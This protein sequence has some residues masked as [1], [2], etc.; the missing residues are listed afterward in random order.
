M[1]ESLFLGKSWRLKVSHE[2]F[3]FLFKLKKTNKMESFVEFKCF[4]VPK[5]IRVD[6]LKDRITRIVS[7][8]SNQW[9]NRTW[10][11]RAS[12]LWKVKE[13]TRGRLIVYG[14]GITYNDWLLDTINH[15]AINKKS[16]RAYE[17][18]RIVVG[19]PI[20]WHCIIFM[21]NIDIFIYQIFDNII[22]SKYIFYL[23]F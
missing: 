6:Y 2:V 19:A 16:Y 17:E 7:L 21:M 3:S 4:Q 14:Y 9:W 22:V 23:V 10:R 5:E 11:N 15:R 18:G 20:S 13:A 8:H 1:Y 12:A